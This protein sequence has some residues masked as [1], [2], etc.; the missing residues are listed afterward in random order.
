MFKNSLIF[1]I[2]KAIS[3]LILKVI[4]NLFFEIKAIV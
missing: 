1:F 4:E 2:A 3:K